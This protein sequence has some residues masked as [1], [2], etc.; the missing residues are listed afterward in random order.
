VAGPEPGAVFNFLRPEVTATT[1]WLSIGVLLALATLV[2]TAA[3]A[4]RARTTR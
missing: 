3:P 4:L 2:L 1:A